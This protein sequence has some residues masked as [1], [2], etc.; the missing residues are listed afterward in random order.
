MSSFPGIFRETSVLPS[1]A[2]RSDTGRFRLLRGSSLETGFEFNLSGWLTWVSSSHAIVVYEQA[3][4]SRGF[5]N[6]ISLPRAF[7]LSILIGVSL[8]GEVEV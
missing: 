7:I 3:L 4:R 1:C 2:G 8:I 5:L 6:R